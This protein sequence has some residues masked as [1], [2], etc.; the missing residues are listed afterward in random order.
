MP[1]IKRF[2]NPLKLVAQL[3]NDALPPT[4][5][6]PTHSSSQVQAPLP[7]VQAS[8]PSVQAPSPL[9]QAPSPSVQAPSQATTNSSSANEVPHQASTQSSDSNVAPRRYAGRESAVC[10]NVETIGIYVY[11]V[12]L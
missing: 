12:Y 4:T 1:R 5:E 7:P 2:Q 9:I 10:W 8:S 3:Q 6:V 11:Y